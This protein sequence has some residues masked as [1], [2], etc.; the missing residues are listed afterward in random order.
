MLL[1]GRGSKFEIQVEVKAGGARRIRVLV[2][3]S[4]ET[5]VACQAVAVSPARTK[6]YAS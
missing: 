6:K 2:K 3:S 1:F 5:F 4:R